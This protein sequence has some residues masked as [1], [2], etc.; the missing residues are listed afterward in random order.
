[1]RVLCVNDNPPGPA[2]GGAEVHLQLLVDALRAAG[3]DVR[4]FSHPGRRGAGR[5]ADVWDRSARRA[6]EAEVE[7]AAP[8]VLHFHNVVRE[9]SVAVLAAAPSVPRVLT[10]HDGRLLGDPDGQ[11][12]ALRAYQ[13]Q[14]ARLDA[15]VARR[16]CPTV[17]AVSGPLEQR[18][19]AAG[20]ADVRRAWPWAERPRVAVAEPAASR[21]LAFVGR[22][23]PDKGVDVLVRAFLRADRSGARLLLA[24]TGSLRL[25]AD[26]RVVRLGRLDR[27]GVSALLGSVRAV[28]LPSLPARR[29]EGS[30]LALVEALVHGRPIVVS[31]DPGCAE[32]ARDGSAGLVVPAGDEGALAAALGRVLDDDVLVGRLAAGA[33][34]AAREHSPEAGLA[35]VRAAYASVSA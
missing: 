18:L 27:A 20:F 10:V 6:L 31:D 22:L 2:H 23:D 11:G 8:D 1:M 4:V 25:P 15:R 28:V 21:D 9:L 26:D 32:L 24:G 34:L 3:D 19:R 5:L 33:A 29:P 17:L 14:R 12:T 35:R 7:R 16:L 13:R 30:P